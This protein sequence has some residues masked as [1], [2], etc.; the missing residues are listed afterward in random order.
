LL[1]R[2]E[3]SG[4]NA[5]IEALDFGIAVLEPVGRPDSLNSP[6]LELQNFLSQSIT[7]PGGFRGVI[8]RAVAFDPKDLAFSSWVA[9][10]YINEESRNA[11]LWINLV[12]SLSQNCCNI[13]LEVT[14]WLACRCPKVWD[15]AGLRELKE[16]A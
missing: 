12:A 15:N 2:L 9:D 3:Y 6:T 16:F 8:S 14:V 7:I 13:D 11:N 1:R 4:L 10:S 5:R